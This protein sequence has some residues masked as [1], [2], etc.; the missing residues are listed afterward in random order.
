MKKICLLGLLALLALIV[1]PATAQ[2]DGFDLGLRYNVVGGDGEPT[3]DALGYGVFGRYRLNER[4]AIGAAVDIT[5]ELDVERTARLVGLVQDPDVKVIDSL[6]E[7]T[8]VTVWIER[9]YARPSGRWE[10]FWTAGA[11]FN[12]VDVT[13]ASGPLAG[14]GTFDIQ[15]VTD[16]ELLLALSGGFRWFFASEWGLEVALRADQHFADWTLTDRV[17]GATGTVDDYL[18]RGVHLGVLYR[19]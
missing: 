2:G 12:S 7:S 11:G 14:G 5:D 19:F 16:T 13:D 4:W 8:A 1:V 15:T 3:N 6:G 9:I 18:V 17:S 10:W